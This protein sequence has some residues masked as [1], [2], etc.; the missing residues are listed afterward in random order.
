MKN[1]IVILCG[2]KGTRLHGVLLEGTPKCLASIG[3]KVFLQIL[4][5]ELQ[6]KADKITLLTGHLSDAIVEATKGWESC[7]GVVV[8]TEQKGTAHA[9]YEYMRAIGADRAIF[10][11][12]DTWQKFDFSHFEKGVAMTVQIMPSGV[13]R[14][15]F[16]FEPR[17]VSGYGGLFHDADLN[18]AFV[19][20]C[21]WSGLGD[22]GVGFDM[23]PEPFYDI[24]TMEGLEEFRRFWKEKK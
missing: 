6:G 7:D 3:D 14:G 9:A 17:R 22:K 13:P 24:G 15:V 19:L 8:D 21:L 23:S 10:I 4:L 2:G 20:R 16:A 11:N 18:A 12:G 5:E 1:E